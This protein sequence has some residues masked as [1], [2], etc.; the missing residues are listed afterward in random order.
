MILIS[1]SSSFLQKL[2]NCS[3]DAPVLVSY[4][5]K[6]KGSLS[7]STFKWRNYRH[8]LNGGCSNVRVKIGFWGL[9]DPVN[10][11]PMLRNLE[12]FLDFSLQSKRIPAENKIKYLSPKKVLDVS[13]LLEN[14]AV[15]NF[16]FKSQTGI[17]LLSKKEIFGIWGLSQLLDSDLSVNDICSYVPTQPL[18]L[19]L[20][21]YLVSRLPKCKRVKELSTPVR[22]PSSNV[23]YFHNIDVSTSNS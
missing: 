11:T 21:S 5:T 15:S 4:E 9:K 20:K 17:R 13:R 16:R 6:D 2:N 12:D 14:V 22:T 19:I 1:G 23:T 18:S 7:R 10:L 8:Y 3:F